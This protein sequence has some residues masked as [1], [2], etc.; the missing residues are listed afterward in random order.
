[1]HF[2]C[3]RKGTNEPQ[4]F[5]GAKFDLGRG[6]LVG[7]P[8]DGGGFIVFVNYVWGDSDNRGCQIN[9][10]IGGEG[11]LG[12]LGDAIAGRVGAANS[13]IVCSAHI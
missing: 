8:L 11:S 7:G 1:M 13:V 2:V 10:W 6:D 3:S 5:V 4:F 12:T 9:V